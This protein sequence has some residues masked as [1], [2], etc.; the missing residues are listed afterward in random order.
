MAPANTAQWSYWVDAESQDA[1]RLLLLAEARGGSRRP[2]LHQSSWMHIARFL[3]FPSPLQNIY[4]FGGRPGGAPVQAPG[5]LGSAMMFD[6]WK[7]EWEELPPLSCKRVGAAAAVY[8]SRIVV[9]G[10]YGDKGNN[11]PL[12]SA[13]AFEPS[14]GTWQALPNMPTARYGLALATVG[15]DLFAIG[16]DSG[17]TGIT[18]AHEVYSESS[19]SWRAAASIPTAVSGG[20]AEVHNQLIYYVG[21]CDPHDRLVS[22]VF[23]YDSTA[24]TWGEVRT[25]ATKGELLSLRCGKT[26]FAMTLLADPPGG[27]WTQ[28]ATSERNSVAKLVVSGGVSATEVCCDT[29]LLPLGNAA[30]E[31]AWEERSRR[32]ASFSRVQQLPPMPLSRMSPRSLVWWSSPVRPFLPWSTTEQSMWTGLR[33]S[34]ARGDSLEPFLLIFGGE[35]V[36]SEEPPALV[37]AEEPLLLDIY[38]ERWHAGEPT[39]WSDEAHADFLKVASNLRLNRS[40]FAVVV[41]DGLPARRRC[42]R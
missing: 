31:A 29:E 38:R 14:T 8:G 20:K 22:D 5:G 25:K 36:T 30:S 7:G 6:W 1:L 28:D 40:A 17:K 37:A 16:G 23:V 9:A 18:A 19:G 42:A 13:E 11:S 15:D 32:S 26:S 2:A 35:R 21:G 34:A 27:G 41:A 4:V 33:T 3:R 12:D 24:D 10:G 39:L